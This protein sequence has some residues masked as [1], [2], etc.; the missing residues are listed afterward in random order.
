MAASSWLLTI[1][2]SLWFDN[3]APRR[4]AVVEEGRGAGAQRTLS[5]LPSHYAVLL[6]RMESAGMFLWTALLVASDWSTTR[7]ESLAVPTR[8]CFR[9]HGHMIKEVQSCELSFHASMSS[10]PLCSA[11]SCL[12]SPP[13]GRLL[14][15][16]LS[17]FP[18]PLTA[19][20][21]HDCLS[22]ELP[23]HTWAPLLSGV[24]II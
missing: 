9:A 11:A 23:F 12:L 19:R 17:F 20:S 15:S 3:Q 4:R 24:R 10:S 16:F 13:C 2:L 8:S 6:H 1:G 18:M 5:G 22:P 21:P 7:T 14:A